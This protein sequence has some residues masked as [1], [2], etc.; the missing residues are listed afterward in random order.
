[1]ANFAHES[2][3]AQMVS[4]LCKRNAYFIHGINL[5]VSRKGGCPPELVENEVFPGS[6]K[7]ESSIIVDQIEEWM[8]IR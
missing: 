1:M 2:I 3:Y 8:G 4:S 5:Y 7:H 6:A